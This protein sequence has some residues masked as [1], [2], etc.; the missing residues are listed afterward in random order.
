MIVKNKSYEAVVEDLTL[1]EN[2]DEGEVQSGG[3]EDR[4][5]VL[6]TGWS[7]FFERVNAVDLR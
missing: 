1:E 3:R 4:E 6:D 2:G 7:A 5:E